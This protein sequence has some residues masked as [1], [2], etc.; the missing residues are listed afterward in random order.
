MVNKDWSSRAIASITPSTHYAR[1]V[2]GDAMQFICDAVYYGLRS[3]YFSA[4]RSRLPVS[5]LSQR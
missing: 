3:R 5:V 1:E 2:D 4:G